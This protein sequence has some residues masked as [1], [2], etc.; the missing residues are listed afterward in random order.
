MTQTTSPKS[1]G[2]PFASFYNRLG[3]AWWVEVKTQQPECVYYFGPFL[4]SG[5]A[6]KQMPGY[7]KDLEDEG[8]V[9][10]ESTVKRCKPTQLTVCK[11][12]S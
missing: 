7:I 1:S 11:D 9:E 2:G 10:I 3:L 4:T 12:E 8:A 6:Q 5:E